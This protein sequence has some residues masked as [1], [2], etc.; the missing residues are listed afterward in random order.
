MMLTP[1]DR[2]IFDM[3]KASDVMGDSVLRKSPDMVEFMFRDVKITIYPNGSL[4]FYHFT[5]LETAE[6]YADEITRLIS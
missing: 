4:M 3:D 5:D 6:G 1:S 2:P